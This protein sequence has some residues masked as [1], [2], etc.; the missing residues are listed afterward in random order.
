MNDTSK[1]QNPLLKA[2]DADPLGRAKEGLKELSDNWAAHGVLPLPPQLVQ[3]DPNQPRRDWLPEPEW[4][5]GWEAFEMIRLQTEP[6]E[7]APA[8]ARI[9]ATITDQLDR[10]TDGAN[11]AFDRL[12][13]TH[14]LLAAFPL[15]TNH[16]FRALHYLLTMRGADG[17]S[18]WEGLVSDLHDWLCPY[19][20]LRIRASDLLDNALRLDWAWHHYSLPEAKQ[21]PIWSFP[22][23]LAWIGTRSYLALA[24]IGYF[25]RPEGEE[26]PVATDGVC[27]YNT[28]ALGW[29]HTNI[30]YSNCHCGA[31]QEFGW[32]AFQHCTCISIAWEELVHFNGG[33]TRQTPELVFNLQEGWL[34]MTWPDGADDLRFLRRDILERW[35]AKPNKAPVARL[36]QSVG[37]AESECRQWL[38]SAFSDDPGNVRSKKSFQE[39]ALQR[40]SGRLSV[41]GF[42]RAWDSVADSEGRSK[43]GRKS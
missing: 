20:H 11:H 29:L 6:Y 40:F 42:L 34:S 27:R 9:C 35:P 26:E 24:R 13:P 22:K 23:A 21:E 12:P 41:R 18:G 8:I 31:L 2:L 10:E 14:E 36:V 38:L 25:R 7:W 28:E 43:P 5:S 16:W 30:T 32:A 17:I 1:R 19:D 37:K 39:E 15:G 3:S 33:L 4:I